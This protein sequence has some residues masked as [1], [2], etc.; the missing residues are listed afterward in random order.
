MTAFVLDQL[1][2]LTFIREFAHDVSAGLSAE[3][4]Q[5]Q[6]KYFYDR[7]GSEL[8]EEI[9]RQPEY[10]LTRAEASI[11]KTYS[12]YIARVYGSI[13]SAIIELGSGSSAKTRILLQEFVKVQQRLYYFPIDISHSALQR[14]LM[15]LSDHLPA[16]KI[17]GLSA[18]YIGGIAKA[19]Q[20]IAGEQISARMIVLFLGSS[21]GNFEPGEA[22]SFLGIIAE[23]LSPGDLVLVGF[24]LHKNERVLNAAYND[25]AGITARFNLNILDRINRELGGEFETRHFRHFAFYNKNEKRIEMHLMSTCR[26]NV[27]IREA[28][29]TFDFD[30][31]ETIHTEN[32]Y[33]YT[34]RQIGQMAKQCGLKVERHF[35]DQ[36]RMFDLAMFRKD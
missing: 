5:L 26:Q 15:A 28:G 13:P 33:K 2:R 35:F 6:P 31:G 29:R 25:S 8:F 17:T 24:D 16:I 7:K 11:L 10:Y 34:V 18:D 9:C 23:K 32:S 12:P 36:N 27:Y 22:E 30:R 1:D 4:K 14:A 19:G 20:L 3:Q 21:I